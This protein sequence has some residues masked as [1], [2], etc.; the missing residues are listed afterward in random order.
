MCTLLLLTIK[1]AE[2]N[3]DSP[4]MKTFLSMQKT[5]RGHITNSLDGLCGDA[6]SKRLMT[7]AEMGDIQEGSSHRQCTR[8]LNHFGMKIQVTPGVFY[9]FVELLGA[10]RTCDGVV[11]QISM[12]MF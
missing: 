1:M 10:L 6:I 4:E 12:C 8:F 7:Y 2:P 3:P 9:Q 11:Q 5:I